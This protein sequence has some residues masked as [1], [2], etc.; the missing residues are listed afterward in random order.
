[1]SYAGEGQHYGT[2]LTSQAR[3]SWPWCHACASLGMINSHVSCPSDPRES[4]LF[5]AAIMQF[6]SNLPRTADGGRYSPPQGSRKR[7]FEDAPLGQ[8]DAKR[9]APSQAPQDGGVMQSDTVY[10]LLIQAKKVGGGFVPCLCW[11]GR[12]A[13]WRLLHRLSVR[14]AATCMRCGCRRAQLSVLPMLPR[15][16]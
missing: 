12:G 6:L 13:A 15:C 2:F 9:Q 8:P 11:G 5:A 16:V 1:M 10:R 4:Q 14:E 7:G 3:P